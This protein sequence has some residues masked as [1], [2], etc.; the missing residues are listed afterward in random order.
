MNITRLI[1]KYNLIKS[2]SD[3]DLY[4]FSSSLPSY[5]H[6]MRIC[7]GEISMA[8]YIML[9]DNTICYCNWVFP[10][11]PEEHIRELHKQ[12]IECSKQYKTI[13]IKRKMVELEEDFK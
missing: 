11:K 3:T 13:Q 5:G 7:N 9:D 2:N 8:G 6:A 4:I 12:L 1:K 10:T